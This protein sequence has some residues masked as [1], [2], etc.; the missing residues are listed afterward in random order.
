MKES[1]SLEFIFYLAAE[2][3]SQMKTLSLRIP[4][5]NTSNQS[6][7]FTGQV[8][9][10]TPPVTFLSTT[11]TKTKSEFVL[12]THSEKYVGLASISGLL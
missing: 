2:K 4:V 3:A 1:L 7:S 5:E 11:I 12:F 6:C 9:E 8:I 10:Q